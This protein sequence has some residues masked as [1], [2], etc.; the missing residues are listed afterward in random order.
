M[1]RVPVLL[2]HS[3]GGDDRRYGVLE[4]QLFLIAGFKH[5]RILIETLDS[6]GKFYAAQ[7]VDG[8]QP[9]VFARIVEK[10]V[11]NVLRRFVHLSL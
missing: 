10:T 1:I 7:K 4:N 11:L 8:H 9:F 5:Q 3:A 2:L 6:P